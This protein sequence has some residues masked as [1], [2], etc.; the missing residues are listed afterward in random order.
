MDPLP[1]HQEI[2]CLTSP[3]DEVGLFYGIELNEDEIFKLFGILINDCSYVLD[4]CQLIED[5]EQLIL[6]NSTIV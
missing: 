4:G 5:F 3:E 6:T 1:V 2:R